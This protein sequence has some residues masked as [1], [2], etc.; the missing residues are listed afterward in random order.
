LIVDLDGQVLEAAAANVLIVEG[1]TVVT[2]PL[3]GRLL[4]GAVRARVLAAA[5][6]VGLG[7][8]EEP[9]TLEPALVET[10]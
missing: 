5:P 8:S 1:A 3:D 9:I 6:S 2:P 4:P 10:R 7:A